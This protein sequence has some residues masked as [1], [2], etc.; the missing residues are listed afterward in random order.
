MKQSVIVAGNLI[1]ALFTPSVNV[2]VTI[3]TG[4]WSLG[5]SP[6]LISARHLSAE[7]LT[8]AEVCRLPCCIWSCLNKS[9]RTNQ[10]FPGIRMLARI[11]EYGIFLFLN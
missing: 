2:T 3:E 5:I 10:L 4:L 6:Y 7:M 11:Y 8:T 1:A 9:K